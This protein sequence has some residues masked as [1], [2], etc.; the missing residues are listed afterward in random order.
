MPL[1]D[2]L[3]GAALFAAVVGAAGVA[4]ALI[5]VRR[6]G[7]L[8]ALERLLAGLVAGT[9]L[10][11]AVHLV[12]LLLGILSRGTVLAAAALALA[13]VAAAVRGAPRP[14]GPP[15]DRGP[16]PGPSGRVSWAL[17]AVGAG[18]ALVAAAADLRAWAGDEVV[19]VDPLTFHLPN[20]GRWIQSGSL[21]QIDQFLP[22]IAHGNYPNNGDVVLLST[23]L[24]WHNDFLARF[25]ITGFAVMAAVAV[26]AIARELRAPAPAA[27]LAGAAVVS[28]PVVGL[29]SIPRAMPDA[30]LYATFACGVL[31]LLRH[32]RT[33]RTSDLLL[34]GTA[35]GI[36]LGT[37]WY[38]VSSVGLLVVLWIGVRLYARRGAI[39]SVLRD[40]VLVGGLAALGGAAWLVRNLVESG[41][42]IFPQKIAPLGITLFDAP[43]DPLRERVGFSIAHYAGDPG[44]L[45]D[46]GLELI[47][48]LGFAVAVCALGVV[49]ALV[50][51]RRDDRRGLATAAGAAALGLLY[52]NTPYTALGLPGEPSLANVNTRYLV[53][54]LV[55]AAP[56]TAW[57]AGALGRRG[58]VALEAALA[59]AVITGAHEGFAVQ[60][61]GDLVKATV[62]LGLLGA[63]GWALWDR[64]AWIARRPAVLAVGGVALVLVALAG[65]HRMQQRVNSDRYVGP[66]SA[67]DAIVRGAPEGRR[68]GLAGAWS[69]EG[70]SPIWPSFG[71][72]V[73]NEVEYVGH[74]VDGFLREYGDARSFRAALRDRGYDLLVVG[75]GLRPPRPMAEERWAAEAGWRTIALS[76]RLRVLAPPA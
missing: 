51:G 50:A 38:G 73:D 18:Y 45:G 34:A 26:Y 6:L 56:V 65:A 31:F 4:A 54:A 1:G 21:W 28:V 74:F 19:G 64:R 23:V 11:I 15:E 63:A 52:V 36:A 55:L 41:N 7:H 58:A 22:L 20:V 66:D 14:P 59:F 42:P 32:A 43:D 13:G 48:G 57:A 40:G 17:A 60:G 16:A 30:V 67:I 37:K 44:V 72:R 70:L 9:A 76:T 3:A 8:D 69:V 27:I 68:I 33:A 49:V 12:P 25:A 10:L 2:L 46:I 53:P 5:V 39:G 75:R 29:S 61:A 47:E 35:L 71:T 24:P 62:A